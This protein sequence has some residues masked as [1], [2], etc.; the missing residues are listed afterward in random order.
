MRVD[1]SAWKLFKPHHYLDAN[2]HRSAKCFVGM[3][4][5]QPAAFVAVLPFPHPSRPG[6]REH[7]A[8]CLPDF[9]GV[10]IGKR[11]VRGGGGD[12]LREQT[13][14]QLHEPPEHDPSPAPLADVANDPQSDADA[15]TDNLY[16]ATA[17]TRDD[18]AA[19]DGFLSYIFIGGVSGRMAVISFETTA[20]EYGVPFNQTRFTSDEL[21]EAVIL[22]R[23][24]AKQKKEAI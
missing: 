2:L 23:L 21:I 24:A 10:G 17:F 4:E 5:G 14:P 13:V 22:A 16:A 18:T 19:A 1:Q 9:Q 20:G 11:D 3:V 6:W 8:V 12:F 7:R 15:S